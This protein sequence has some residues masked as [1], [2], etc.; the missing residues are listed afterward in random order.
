MTVLERK[1]MDPTLL[2]GIQAIEL[3]QIQKLYAYRPPRRYF[4]RLGDRLHTEFLGGSFAQK[5]RFLAYLPYT[6][7]HRSGFFRASPAQRAAT[8]IPRPVSSQVGPAEGEGRPYRVAISI[9]GSLGDFMHHVPLMQAF[10]TRFAPMQVDFFVHNLKLDDRSKLAVSG[11]PFIRQVLDISDLPDLIAA[12]SY[13][14]QIEIKHIVKYHVFKPAPG[15]WKTSLASSRL[16]ERRTSVSSLT[17]SSSTCIPSST[18]C[19]GSS[20]LNAA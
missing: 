17:G 19:S 15:P 9:M 3:A 7:L 13:E 18:G 5:L 8:A 10:H 20:W 12:G 11:L 4:E 14:L 2:K 6:V 16:S 1:G